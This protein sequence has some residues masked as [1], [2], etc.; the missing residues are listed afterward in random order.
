MLP[1]PVCCRIR[2]LSLSLP[3]GTALKRFVWLA[4][5]FFVVSPLA[6]AEQPPAPVVR[7]LKNPTGVTID[8]AGR[9]YVSTAG[10]IG[11]DGDGAVLV[12]DKGKAMA[13]AS[14]LDD[15]RGIL[16]RGEW[17]FVAD[18][19][20]VW[21]IDRKGKAS[22][23]AAAGAF[24]PPA[25]SLRDLDVDETGALY[26][27]DE[28]G[29]AIYRI[30]PKG[31]VALV[32]DSKRSP[33]L[34]AP[35]GIALDGFS[36]LLVSDSASGQLLRLRLADGGTQKL[37]EGF[38]SGSLTWDKHG[39]LYGSDGG[40]NV[41]VISRPGEK[42]VTLTAGFQT[43][44]GLCLGAGGKSIL[45]ADTKAGTV[46]VLDASVPGQE[47]D[48][49]P[50]PL[51]AA[52]A[53]PNLKWTGWQPV[54]DKGK[55]VPLRPIVLTH[56]GDG[57]NRVFVATQRGVIHVFPNDQ[58]ATKTSIFLDIRDRVFY[59]DDEN[60]QG[61][62]GLAFHPNFK[63]NGEFFVFYTTKKAR[64]TNVVSR[65]RVRRDDPSRADPDSEEPLLRIAHAFWNHDGGTICFG[66]DGYLYI[67]LGD[68]GSANDPHENGQNLKTL[69]GKVL[70]IDVDHKSKSLPYAIP[71]DNPF[72]ARIDARPEIWAYG[73]RNVWRMAFDRKTGALWAADVGQNLY[74]EIDL[75]VSGGNYGWNRREGLHPFGARGAGVRKD[76]ID[77]IWEY[78]HDVGKSITGGLVYRGER[79]PELQG[80]YLYA[81]YVSARIWALRYDEGQR[82]VV[83]NR[84][85]RDPN[86]PV[87]SFG[88]DEKGEAYFLTYSS[89]GQGIYRFVKE[90]AGKSET[91]ERPRHGSITYQEET[92]S[93][94]RRSQP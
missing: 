35:A 32:T 64:L 38:G 83:A 1:E 44:A 33:A 70:R 46:T 59:S 9:I 79:L 82:R 92:R 4:G 94:L 80:C 24:A 28:K 37:A 67:A 58:K 10:E 7:D 5:I 16:A 62:L 71:K 26:V 6:A 57:S 36:H 78:H 56:A 84:P 39:R 31:K 12:I 21:R 27:S 81:D 41:F 54:N 77:P 19:K 8:S 89:T 34:K 49:R 29:G 20:R 14:G 51:K 15:P 43:A 45:V 72:V 55:A 3:G 13:F 61:L 17:L 74:E 53:F 93:R 86:V 25:Q 42:P 23:F 66:P 87:M 63:K 40:R 69:L 52:V 60:E 85:L 68:G 11:K 73:L 48:Q 76:L 30:D 75:I 47:V 91:R 88:E 18:N 65:F 50:L 90:R 22:V 2:S